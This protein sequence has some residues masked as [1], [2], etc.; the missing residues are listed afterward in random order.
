MKFSKNTIWNE[1]ER[2][3]TLNN[4]SANKLSTAILPNNPNTLYGTRRNILDGGMTV[5]FLALKYFGLKSIVLMHSDKTSAVAKVEVIVKDKTIN[6][7]TSSLVYALGQF[8]YLV[9]KSAIPQTLRKAM[10]NPTITNITLSTFEKAFN[11]IGDI[12]VTFNYDVP[13]IDYELDLGGMF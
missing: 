13:T 11:V 12:E 1:C 7:I 8:A 10:N 5:P 4:M 3:R 6:E 9:P 2:Q